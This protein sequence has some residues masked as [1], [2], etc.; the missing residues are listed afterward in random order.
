[1][2]MCCSLTK[3]RQLIWCLGWEKL[4]A[5]KTVSDTSGRPVL[6]NVPMSYDEL[7]DHLGVLDLNVYMKVDRNTAILWETGQV[8]GSGNVARDF[9]R[10]L[11]VSYDRFV[12]LNGTLAEFTVRL[13]RRI[14]E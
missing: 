6:E 5:M 8:D 4:G 7:R 9:N 1:M 3:R 14:P 10:S 2:A 13:F 11:K 12:D